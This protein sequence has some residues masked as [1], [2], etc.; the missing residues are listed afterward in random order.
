MRSGRNP[1]HFRQYP[2]LACLQSTPFNTM[3]RHRTKPTPKEPE[4]FPANASFVTPEGVTIS[5]IPMR[6]PEFGKKPAGRTLLDI[7]EAKRPRD[8]KGN[9]I[10]VTTEEEVEVF[11]H[12][13]NTFFFAV[14]LT[15]LLFW[16]DVLVH[17]QYK[18]EKEWGL[19]V[20]RCAKAFPGIYL[21][22]PIPPCAFQGLMRD[23]HLRD[24]LCLP[25]PTNLDYSAV[26]PLGAEYCGR[27]LHRQ[28]GQQVRLLLCDEE[29]A[30][31]RNAVDLGGHRDGYSWCP[32]EFGGSLGVCVVLR[33]SNL[34]GE[35]RK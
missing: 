32:C 35:R 15:I 2:Q 3:A 31:A 12:A 20:A 5:E 1:G 13:A 7:I 28:G 23:S 6:T 4:L 8:A 18:Q 21:P 22:L 16:L 19:V 17:M 11:G 33:I 29:D 34:V 10:G 14:P 24:P 30:A 27:V 9:P 26:V 25:P